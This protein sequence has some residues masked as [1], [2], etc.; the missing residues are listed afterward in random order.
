MKDT[1]T[2]LCLV[3]AMLRR[4]MSGAADVKIDTS[5]LMDLARITVD[6]S[7]LGEVADVEGENISDTVT[8]TATATTDTTAAADRHT[9]LK[10]LW[11]GTMDWIRKHA[12]GVLEGMDGLR[13]VGECES[14]IMTAGR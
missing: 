8:A 14:I 6:E 9:S 2:N 1:K 4:V 11:T 3:A 5:R 7:L 13:R 10:D 12:V